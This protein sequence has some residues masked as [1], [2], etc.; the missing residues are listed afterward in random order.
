MI[1]LELKQ[2][3]R[4]G[5][6]SAMLLPPLLMDYSNEGGSIKK[7][8]QSTVCLD[9]ATSKAG[10]AP[11][12]QN[13]K[14]SSLSLQFNSKREFTLHFE[15]QWSILERLMS[16]WLID[17]PSPITIHSKHRSLLFQSLCDSVC[18]CLYDLLLVCV[19]R[20]DEG[21]VYFF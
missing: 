10:H 21:S 7:F 19:A 11:S 4:L 17:H 15:S 3:R 9:M 8:I 12:I 20:E 2:L 1:C 14:P 5:Q 6:K 16:R 18:F 13:Q